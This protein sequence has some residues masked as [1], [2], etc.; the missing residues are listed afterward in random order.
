MYI[1]I[2]HILLVVSFLDIYSS[3]NKKEIINERTAGLQMY[4]VLT[5]ERLVMAVAA[6]DKSNAQLEMCYT[7][8]SYMYIIHVFIIC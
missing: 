1:Q 6:E 3:L 2:P 5:V 7:V 8:K 4:F